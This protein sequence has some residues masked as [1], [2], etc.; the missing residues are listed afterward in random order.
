[1]KKLLLL[2][3]PFLFLI[4][5]TSFAAFSAACTGGTVTTNGAYTVHKFTSSGTLVC[6]GLGTQDVSIWV[7]AG[8]GGGGT[9]TGAGGGAGGI[10]TNTA[11]SIASVN[12]MVVIGP[13][14]A[15]DTV[16]SISTFGNTAGTTTATGGGRGCEDTLCTGVSNGGG[17]G[18]GGSRTNTGGT[19]TPNQGN[20]GGDGGAAGGPSY[21][22][23][24]AGGGCSTKGGAGDNAVG[25]GDGGNGCT[26]TLTGTSLVHGRGG[27]GGCYFATV[28]GTGGGHKGV[29]GTGGAG[30]AGNPCG[31]GAANTGDGGGG[32]TDNGGAGCA[33]GSGIVIISYLTPGAG[34]DTF[35]LQDDVFIFSVSPWKREWE[36]VA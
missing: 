19:S 1:M 23:Q 21:Y 15:S 4:P 17:S 16:G 18:A 31:A 25:G 29:A 34:T 22:G 32:R 36:F 35:Q 2:I 8:G 13:G 10:A 27:G 14:G 33:G 9:N 24:G 20:N 26:E 6:D 3:L 7:V 30:N 11:L 28:C 12:S 5:H